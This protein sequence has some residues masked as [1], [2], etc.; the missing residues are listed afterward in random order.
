MNSSIERDWNVLVERMQAENDGMNA[1][2]PTGFYRFYGFGGVNAGL[3]FFCPKC[4][5]CVE[6]H[7]PREV[8]HC[9]RVDV[10]PHEADWR[11]ARGWFGAIRRAMLPEFCYGYSLYRL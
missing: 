11:S 5:L 7:S 10:A 2:R 8:R 9:G 1:V 3:G 6:P 4:R